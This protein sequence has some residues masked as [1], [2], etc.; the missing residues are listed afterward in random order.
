MDRVALLTEALVAYSSGRP[1]PA[2]VQDW[3]A[4]ALGGMGQLR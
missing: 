3:L 1:L 4:E 2:S